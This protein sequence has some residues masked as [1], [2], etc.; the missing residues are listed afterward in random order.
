MTE[1]KVASASHPPAIDHDGLRRL[2]PRELAQFKQ[3]G[4]LKIEALASSDDVLQVR[5]IIDRLYAFHQKECGSIDGL[6]SLGPELKDTATYKS[7][8]AIAK[9]ILGR[10]TMYACDNGLYKEPHGKH[11][12]PWHQDGAFHGR[13]FPNNTVA[14]WIPLQDVA[15]ENGCMHYIPLRK[16]QILMP[17]R[18]YYPN[19]YRS[20]TT[21]GIDSTLEVVCPLHVG[22]ATIH[23]PFTL[24]SAMANSTDFIRRTW[25]LTF[26]PWGKWGFFA[27]SRLLHRVRIIQDRLLWHVNNHRAHGR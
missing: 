22:D 4:F 9:Q 3:Q 25:L 18:P 27:P 12:T 20:V 16:G 6:L 1:M 11:G 13:Y 24:H 19:D 26:R 2:S 8:L 21:D 14:F 10:T 5:R 15:L 23:G 7:C 17:H